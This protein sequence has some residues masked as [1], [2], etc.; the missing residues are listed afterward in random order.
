MTGDSLLEREERSRLLQERE[1]TEETES[2]ERER[3]GRERE[4]LLP[5]SGSHVRMWEMREVFF[6]HL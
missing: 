1:E 3:R 4:E 6:L 2:G 5:S